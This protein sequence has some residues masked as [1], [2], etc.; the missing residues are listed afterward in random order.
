[1]SKLTVYIGRFSPFHN[2]H[3]ETLERALKSSDR[4]LVIIGSAYQARTIKNPWTAPERALMINSCFKQAVANGVLTTRYAR[5]I[6][7]NDE[8]WVKQIQDIV[9]DEVK[10]IEDLDVI[11]LTG[12]DRDESTFYLKL[13]PSWDLDIVRE[14]VEVT[15]FLTATSIRD[16][17]F[18]RQIAGRSVS[19]AELYTI[20]QAFVRQPV[21]EALKVFD[22]PNNPIFKK[23]REEY[24]IVS[25]YKKR[26]AGAPFP[27]TFVTVDAVVIE[28][29]HVL[30]VE[31][32]GS[33]LGGGLWAL[34][35]GF[36][37]Q[38]ERIL[39]GAVRELR[40]ETRLK[41]PE[42]VLRGSLKHQQVF[43]NPNRSLRGRTITHAFLFH[44]NPQSQGLSLVKGGDDAADAFWVPLNEALGSPEKFFED[45]HAIIETMVGK[46]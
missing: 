44:L 21:L 6:P 24:Y 39:D 1:M 18:G 46:L 2:G 41:V 22:H 15:K 43:D 42:P 20:L 25:D 17:Y 36:L 7:Y 28:A 13:F 12:A 38:N 19:D 3:A 34:P 9:A 11:V 45:H 23:L 30:L 4:V 40:E 5:D 29:G 14:N 32:E 27:P 10:T 8:L 31:R 33:N 16:L 37:N 26:W 35:G